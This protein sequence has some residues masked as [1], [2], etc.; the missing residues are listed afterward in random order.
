MKLKNVAN[1]NTIIHGIILRKFP[2]SLE[3]SGRT[4]SGLEQDTS[5]EYDRDSGDGIGG[6]EY[7]VA[8]IY[9]N[10]F[11]VSLITTISVEE[12]IPERVYM[13]NTGAELNHIKVRSVHTNT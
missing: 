7:R 4:S 1:V 12:L 10:K 8:V 2:K 5:D 9:P 6:R 3:A 13:L 11:P